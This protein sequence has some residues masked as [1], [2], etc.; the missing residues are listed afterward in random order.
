MHFK[1][2][3]IFPTFERLMAEQLAACHAD[4]R[5]NATREAAP[6]LVCLVWKLPTRW[7]QLHGR[8]QAASSS[9]ARLSSHYNATRA[10]AAQRSLS[11]QLSV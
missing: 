6:P 5:F 9:F 10:H 7:Q 11:G 1:E 8:V 4:V 2:K 3:G